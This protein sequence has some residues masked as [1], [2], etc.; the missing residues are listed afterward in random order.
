MSELYIVKALSSIMHGLDR[1]A[2]MRSAFQRSLLKRRD[3]L[4]LYVRMFIGSM[5]LGSASCEQLNSDILPTL[6]AC[7]YPPI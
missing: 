6:L 2:S 7:V 4:I 3:L 1:R 5:P